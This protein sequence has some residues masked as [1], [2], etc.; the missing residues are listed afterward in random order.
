MRL[1]IRVEPLNKLLWT[2]FEQTQWGGVKLTKV[3]RCTAQLALEHDISDYNL[4]NEAGF[5]F[6]FLNPNDTHTRL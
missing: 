5:F 3:C 4:S 1:K 2:Q 6:S